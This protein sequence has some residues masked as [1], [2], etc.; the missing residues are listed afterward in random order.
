MKKRQSHAFA[1]ARV[2]R[3]SVL[4]NFG[5]CSGKTDAR[6]K[7]NGNALR[8]RSP[9]ASDAR[10]RR[11]FHW[12]DPRNCHSNPRSRCGGS[13]RPCCT[14]HRPQLGGSGDQSRHCRCRRTCGTPVEYPHFSTNEND[15]QSRLK[16][17]RAPSSGRLSLGWEK[18]V[19]PPTLKTAPVSPWA[20]STRR[21]A[22][23][24]AA[25]ARKHAV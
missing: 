16:P 6:S 5:W 7:A 8:Q 1:H 23:D 2:G 25:P 24:D 11:R 18:A 20:R 4:P 13:I 12:P 14:R 10:R 15:C 22:P 21:T 9:M 17:H 19:I 3:G